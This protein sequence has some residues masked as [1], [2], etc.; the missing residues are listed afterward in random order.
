M[1]QDLTARGELIE[2]YW[3]A[4]S[5]SGVNTTPRLTVIQQIYAV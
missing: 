5:Q 4:R 3:G 2:A 1:L